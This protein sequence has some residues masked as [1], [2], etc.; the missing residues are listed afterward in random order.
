MVGVYMRQGQKMRWG[1]YSSMPCRERLA[2][3]GGRHS[4][5]CSA[6]STI[7]SAS[8]RDLCRVGW[9]KRVEEEEG[10]AE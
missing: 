5:A 1:T 8:L 2:G 4:R 3:E 10:E 7:F 9:R 6:P